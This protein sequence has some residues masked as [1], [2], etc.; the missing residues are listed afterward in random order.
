[1]GVLTETMTKLRNEIVS[2]KHTRQVSQQEREQQTADRRSQV[3]TLC[4]GFARDLAGARSAWLGRATAET[5]GKQRQRR[6]AE[7]VSAPA[8]ATPKR[9]PAPKPAVKKRVRHVP[10]VSKRKVKPSKH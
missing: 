6:P 2:A 4:M 10:P 7:L 5:T 9:H 1:M 3:S 8:K